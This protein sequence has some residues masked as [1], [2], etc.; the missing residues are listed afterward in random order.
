MKKQIIA[1]AVLLSIAGVAF[2]APNTTQPGLVTQNIANAGA[3]GTTV[4]KLAKI[5]SSG[6]L[7]ISGAGDTDNAAGIVLSG[8]G[9]T[10]SAQI[11]TA[12]IASC[13]F[14][15][16]T[17]AGHY[18][19]ISASVAGDCTDSG[20]ATRPSSGQVIGV[21][22]STNGGGGTYKVALQIGSPSG[23]GSGTV[24][25]VTPGSGL[26]SG[27]TASCA[28]TAIT[29]TGTLS[30]AKCINA[31]TG[32]TY[33]IADGD[34]GKFVTAFN[35]A[36]QAY[37]IAQA[38]TASAFANGWYTTIYNKSTN[39]LGIVT[40]T[41]TTST[42]NGSA[43][44]A[45][46]PGQTAT[47]VS[48]GTNYQATVSG[49]GSVTSVGLT[50]TDL[51]VSGSP[52]T[53]SGSIT[54]NIAT[55][56]VTNAKLAQMTTKT[57]KA[58][59]TAGTADPT[60]VSQAGML[61]ALRQTTLI[62][63]TSGVDF[64]SV[65]DT[66]ITVPT[67]PTGYT[68][69]SVRT[70][71]IDGASGTLTNST[72]GLFTTTGGGGTAFASSQAVTVATASEGTNTNMQFLTINNINSQSYLLASVPTVYFRVTNPQGTAATATVTVNFLA[73]P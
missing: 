29:T 36:A 40:V 37:S 61:A 4:N 49:P 2:A 1:L 27:V 15:G 32:T 60:D 66:A 25:S 69:F 24:T 39:A 41:P 57:Y 70:I 47:I 20:A 56:A 17:T 18:V 35:A 16:A 13:V 54:A 65:A 51:S 53:T 26:V 72:V 28:Q 7:V 63:A 33:A 50:S 45:I 8:A 23:G 59:V 9:T 48:D 5:D 3:T 46:A 38:G 71:V 12:G 21:V 31:Q 14:D 19:Q 52:V 58:N 10:G 6:A 67:L 42:I 30:S 55:N 62:V 11:A 22:L 64:N 34:R 44:L 68:R 73:L 43:T